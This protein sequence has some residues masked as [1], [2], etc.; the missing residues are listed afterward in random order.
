MHHLTR[1]DALTGLPNEIHFTELLTAAIERSQRLGQS[2]V[3]LESNIERLSEINDSLGF[4]HGDQVLQE[5][6]ARLSTAAP[7]PAVVAR[8]RGDEFAI[9]LP[10]STQSDA[11]ALVQHLEGLLARPFPVAD[12][13]LE[14]S[15][16]IGVA[17]F[18]Q[19]GATPTTCFATWTLRCTR[20]RKGTQPRRF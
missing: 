10:D 13:V 16:K 20:P 8:L 4:A 5:F 9:L 12:I 7:E 11:L 3:V 17:L 18:P 14:V 2:F 19:H 15:T 1:Y 6:G